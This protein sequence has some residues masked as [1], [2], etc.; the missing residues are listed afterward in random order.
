MAYRQATTGY[1]GE[2]ARSIVRTSGAPNTDD[3]FEGRSRA[4][5]RAQCRC[6]AMHGRPIGRTSALPPIP[7]SRAT[8]RKGHGR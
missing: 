8:A 5:V 4:G 7:A 3:D 6:H 2:R 1:Q